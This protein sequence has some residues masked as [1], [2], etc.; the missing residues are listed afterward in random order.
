M[1]EQKAKKEKEQFVFYSPSKEE[2]IGNWIRERKFPDGTI[3]QRAQSL[4]FENHGFITTDK[5]VANFIRKCNSYKIKKI[6]EVTVEELSR[7]RLK[8]SVIPGKMEVTGA[9]VNVASHDGGAA[10]PVQVDR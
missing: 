7:M 3:E 4:A 9:P 8:H 1:S 2:R 5:S 10:V 6:R